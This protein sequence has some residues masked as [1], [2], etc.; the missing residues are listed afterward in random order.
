MQAHPKSTNTPPE[1]HF[2]PLAN[3]LGGLLIAQYIHELHRS[4]ERRVKPDPDHLF[5][6]TREIFLN[7]GLDE[8][9]HLQF[10]E[11]KIKK[12]CLDKLWEMTAE[13]NPGHPRFQPEPDP[14]TENYDWREPPL[15][16]PQISRERLEAEIASWYVRNKAQAVKESRETLSQTT[17]INNKPSSSNTQKVQAKEHVPKINY[18]E[19]PHAP[20]KQ[21]RRH[22]RAIQ[23]SE[24]VGPELDSRQLC[25]EIASQLERQG[26]CQES[27]EAFKKTLSNAQQKASRTHI[28]DG[29]ELPLKLAKDS[30]LLLHNYAL[31]CMGEKGRGKSSTFRRIKSTQ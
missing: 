3:E 23:A 30:S 26:S 15:I 2:H 7:G 19:N 29:A 27:F 10:R 1:W 18:E 21:K 25:I 8:L 6:I 28:K 17:P 24:L 16:E 31:T 4:P 5:Q 20:S 13:L 11:T 9:E 22:W 12:L 14:D